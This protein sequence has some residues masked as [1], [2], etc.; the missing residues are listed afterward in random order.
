MR[1]KRVTEY[2]ST[3]HVAEGV[4]FRYTAERVDDGWA[5]AIRRLET[6]AGIRVAK[7]G[8]PFSETVHDLLSLCKAVAAEFE[9]LGDD[10]RSADHGHR[11]RIT[12]A[13]N[14]AYKIHP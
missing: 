3:H 6:V 14:R 8:A 1:F 2:G 4:S 13:V 5:L 7:P 9:K 11:E 10:Y 12:E